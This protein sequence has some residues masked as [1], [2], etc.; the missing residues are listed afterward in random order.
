MSQH[1]YVIDNQAG[2]A[3]RS[4]LNSVLSAIAT[5]NSGATAPTTTY[6]YQ[7]W[8]D[9]SVTPSLL[10]IRDASNSTWIVVGDTSQANLGLATQVGL[11]QEIYSSAVA[12]GTS[13]ALVAAFSP[14]ITNATL[15]SGSVIL[16]VKATAANLSTTPTFTPNS[17]VVA[18]ATIVKGNQLPLAVADI[19][20]AG[21]WLVLA[22]DVANSNWVL[23]NPAFG[24]TVITSTTPPVR[25]TVLSGVTSSSG[26]AAMLS[27][28]TGLALNLAATAT[29][30]RTAFAQGT[31]DFISTVSA[32]VTGVVSSLPASEISYIRQDYVGPT[33][34]TWSSTLAPPQYG[35][36]YNQ[37]AQSLLQFGGSS[38]STTI[39]DDFGNT[40]TA[41]GS[42]KVQ[43][44]QYKFGSGALGGGGTSNA[45]NGTTDYVSS[46]NFTNLGNGSWSV[47]CWFY[48]T[49][50]AT[51]STQMILQAC[52][53][54]SAGYGLV[55]G[56]QN[57]KM[58]YQASTGTSSFDILNA[59]VGTATLASNS[60]N[61]TEVTYDSVAGKYFAYLN[62]VLDTSLTSSLKVAPTAVWSL[63]AS[64]VSTPINFFAGYIDKFEF[65]PYCQHP[66]GTT[67][68]VPTA[69]PSI[70]ATGYT[71][72][73]FSISN[74]TMYQ[75]AAASAV[76]GSNP[77]FTPKNRVYVGEVTTTAVAAVNVVNYALRRA[78][79]SGLFTVAIGGSYVKSHNLGTPSLVSAT[80][81][82]NLTGRNERPATSF[83]ITPASEGVGWYPGLATAN[84]IGINTGS[85]YVNL[86][87]SGAT[88]VT[89]GAY[90]IR[91]NGTF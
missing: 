90:R 37:A 74:Y 5:Q 53:S 43:N 29:P 64:A 40:W 25:Q 11:Q 44:T 73:W 84:S 69:A 2:L 47:R 61:Y 30:L 77:T 19:A 51:T 76:A 68:A 50:V 12:T 54:V 91:V 35:Y 41:R 52:A 48:C 27:A 66:N 72:D 31:S 3:F 62:G 65:L 15:A 28:G 21:H 1:D 88:A 32:D 83:F 13:D 58:F 89:S 8:V 26:Y 7:I 33:T 85:V 14:A 79:D 39:L 45:L 10:R 34:T 70:T 6:A 17:G 71:S 46:T 63:G 78:Y 18:A 67:Y 20:G 75:V 82:D 81:A 4:D 57:S 9:T 56:V 80:F 60:W 24:V 49:N 22:R 55:V 16:Y 38:G 86:N 23:L 42:A 87:T 36:S 59:V